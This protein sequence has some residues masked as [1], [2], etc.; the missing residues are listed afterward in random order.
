MPAVKLQANE[1][2]SARP[3]SAVR[4][5]AWPGLHPVPIVALGTPSQPVEHMLGAQSAVYRLIVMLERI[6]L[7]RKHASL[8]GLLTALFARP[9]RN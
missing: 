6:R 7:P 2:R 8:R 4:T 3:D 9:A 1:T 5:P